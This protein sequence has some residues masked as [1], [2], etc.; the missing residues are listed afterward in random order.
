MVATPIGNLEDITLRALRV[1]KEVDVVAAE[2]TRRTRKLLAHHGI[3]NRVSAYHGYNRERAGEK[4]LRCLLGG[5]NVALVTDGGTPGI[6]DPGREL[7]REAFHRG[8]LVAPV[9]GPSAITAALSVAA[10]SGGPFLFVGFLPSKAGPR[11]R[12]LEDLRG[13]PYLLVL[14]EAPHRL[15]KTLEEMGRVFGGRRILM[16]R[17]MTKVHETL[18]VGT[19]EEIRLSL[20]AE[21]VRG[22]ITL[23]VEPCDTVAEPEMGVLEE[24]RYWSRR[25]RIPMMEVVKQVARSRGI[26]KSEV[27]RESLKLNQESN[28]S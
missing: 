12:K 14:F 5:K 8:V 23:L 20:K 25:S 2:D 19:A 24:L 26:P 4:L 27:Y 16:A 13:L 3:R 28:E 1:L 6:S 7:V 9:P 10:F 11:K 22:E 15:M 17:E 21:V 18:L